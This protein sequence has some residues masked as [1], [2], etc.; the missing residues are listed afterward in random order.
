MH[1]EA[2]AASHG[3]RWLTNPTALRAIPATV[4]RSGLRTVGCGLWGWVAARRGLKKSKE[5]ARTRATFL[6]DIVTKNHPKSSPNPLNIDLKS[7]K[8]RVRR[9]LER[10]GA[11]SGS[12]VGPQG[13]PGAPTC[14]KTTFEAPLGTPLWATIFGSFLVFSVFLWHAFSEGGFGRLPGVF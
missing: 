9:G 7:P 2:D 3:F 14:P 13:G 8:M 5:I 6:Q 10:P 4:P 1:V 11:R 12:H